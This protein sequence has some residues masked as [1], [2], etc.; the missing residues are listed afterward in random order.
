MAS[1][2]NFC[3]IG[4]DSDDLD[5]VQNRRIFY[6]MVVRVTTAYV[7]HKRF[8]KAFAYQESLGFLTY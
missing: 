4:S 1:G 6:T 2:N 8:D 7:L 5:I 3:A